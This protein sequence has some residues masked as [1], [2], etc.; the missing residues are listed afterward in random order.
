MVELLVSHM[1]TCRIGHLIILQMKLRNGK[2]VK[3]SY[4]VIVQVRDD[5]V[6]H[7]IDIYANC[8]EPFRRCTQQCAP[9]LGGHFCTKARIH[10]KSVLRI[11][12]HPNKIIHRHWAIVGIPT[13]KV[14]FTQRVA[15]GIAHGKHFIGWQAA[16]ATRLAVG[17]TVL[18]EK[19][20]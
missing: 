15:R 13:D 10:N 20:C 6:F 18:P 14:I 4:M 19:G 2:A 7:L 17:H 1:A 5:H 8:S 11:T 16:R 9:T 12:Y 3:G